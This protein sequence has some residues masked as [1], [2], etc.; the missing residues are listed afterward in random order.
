MSGEMTRREQLGKL[1]SEGYAL[2]GEIEKKLLVEGGPRE[3]AKL[4]L[5]LE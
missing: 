2:V 5:D 3:Q 1:L 4:R